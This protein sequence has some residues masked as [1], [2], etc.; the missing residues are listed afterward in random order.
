MQLIKSC[1]HLV[2][3]KYTHINLVLVRPDS[4]KKNIYIYFL[5]L[6]NWKQILFFLSTSNLRFKLIVGQ[7]SFTC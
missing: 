6:S 5:V 1:I 4:K 3:K 7:L 2:E